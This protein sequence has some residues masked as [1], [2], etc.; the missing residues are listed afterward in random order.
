MT[1]VGLAV[2]AVGVFAFD[3]PRYSK[4][5]EAAEAHFPED[6]AAFDL[7]SAGD[8]KDILH[9][10]G[11]ATY[12]SREDAE[13]QITIRVARYRPFGNWLLTAIER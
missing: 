2:V 3:W 13:D 8:V 5:L 7:S 6:L 10:T 11:F 4:S 9:Q 1:A 12:T